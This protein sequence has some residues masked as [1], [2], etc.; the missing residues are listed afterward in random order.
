MRFLEMSLVLAELATLIILS[1]KHHRR[2]NALVLLLLA[3]GLTLVHFFREGYRWQ[4]TPAYALLT[5]IYVWHR[6]HPTDSLRWLGKSWL[7]GWW[8]LAAVIPV[9]LPDLTL[10]DPGGPY[11]VGTE[12]AMVIDSSRAEWFTQDPADRRRLVVQIWYPARS[13]E[14]LKPEPYLDHMELRGPA[15]LDQLELPDYLKPPSILTTY[16]SWF[17]T[18]AYP[19]ADPDTSISPVV[20]LSPGLG[21]SRRLHQCLAEYL[22]SR[23]HAVVI[24]D[25]PY[26]A[27]VVVFP[28]GSLADYRSD[29]SGLTPADSSRLR[30]RQLR[31]RVD[32]LHFVLTELKNGLLFH[33]ILGPDPPQEFVLIGHSFGGATVFQT[34][35]ERRDLVSVIALDG[36]NLALPDSSL[37]RGLP[38]PALYLGRPRWDNPENYRRLA[39]LYLANTTTD[40]TWLILHDVHHFDFADV[41]LLSPLLKWMGK[42]GSIPPRRVVHMVNSL[43]DGYIRHQT[44][45]FPEVEAVA[46]HTYLEHVRDH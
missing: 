27:H 46:P 19:G 28:D 36:W 23:G 4:M 12:T 32:D 43:I 3:I 11:T 33:S 30:H 40:H 44:I 9:C 18:H 10:P 38:V 26:D 31:T 34:A 35:R 41:P 17:R 16:F 25:H 20:V 37:K 13:A 22:A 29:L 8:A 6:L 7:Y 39:R 24:I 21:G 1:R 5:A 45:T 2:W 15:M 42:Q 14:G